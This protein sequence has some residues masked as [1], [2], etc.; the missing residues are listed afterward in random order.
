MVLVWTALVMLVMT[1]SMT[2][3]AAI[4]QCNPSGLCKGNNLHEIATATEAATIT[5]LSCDNLA[6]Q[7]VPSSIGLLTKLSIL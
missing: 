1:G 7:T 3:V 2:E 4:C 5:L 6:D